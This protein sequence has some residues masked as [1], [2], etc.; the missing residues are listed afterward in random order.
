MTA[1]SG[2]AASTIRSGRNLK[3]HHHGK[4]WKVTELYLRECGHAQRWPMMVPVTA[5]IIAFPI[6]L[7]IGI[8]KTLHIIP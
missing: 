3:R 8:C 2:I 6:Y 4:K 5:A 1:R 7:L